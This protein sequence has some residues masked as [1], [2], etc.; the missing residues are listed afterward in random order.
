MLSH[1]SQFV[2]PPPELCDCFAGHV[3]FAQPNATRTDSKLA[4]AKAGSP[5]T[6]NATQHQQ[7][8]TTAKQAGADGLS[9]SGNTPSA[10]QNAHALQSVADATSTVQAAGASQAATD[11]PSRA[12]ALLHS[13]NMTA[14][15]VQATA[16]L[17][18][19]LLKQALAQS[20]ATA[21][22]SLLP[23]S[24]A[25]DSQQAP[26]TQQPSALSSA[27][28]DAAVAAGTARSA[29][30]QAT[31]ATTEQSL[32]LQQRFT[33]KAQEQRSQ[34][35][36]TG[37][38]AAPASTAEQESTSAAVQTAATSPGV[39][40]QPPLP[41]QVLAALPLPFTKQTCDKQAYAA[42][43][44]HMSTHTANTPLDTAIG[45]VFPPE[46]L[47]H[48]LD[49]QCMDYAYSRCVHTMEAADPKA[50]MPYSQS[51]EPAAVW[52]TGVLRLIDWLVAVHQQGVAANNKA[53]RQH[54]M[55]LGRTISE[56]RAQLQVRRHCCTGRQEQTL[57]SGP[58]LI[59][60]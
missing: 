26:E 30:P 24:S 15:N 40:T 33:P 48:P 34:R 3:E 27:F 20:S 10:A 19:A 17:S 44:T 18:L 16:R 42:F 41:G 57:L 55:D 53:A 13:P 38:A 50:D 4:K 1:T 9:A 25:S 51:S 54:R 37:A 52:C 39:P 35:D 11:A 12:Q 36:S 22:H 32:Q 14:S 28:A 29:A 21:W 6:R 58:K 49:P 56:A 8:G 7:Q 47:H 45:S 23:R 5:S 60:S 2:T 46:A 59:R 31:Q 43:A